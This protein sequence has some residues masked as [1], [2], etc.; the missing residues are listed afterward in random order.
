MEETE[1][2]PNYMDITIGLILSTGR[3]LSVSDDGWTGPNVSQK[4]GQSPP[5]LIY[6]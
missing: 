5:F 4:R 1:A 2:G 3:G 6:N